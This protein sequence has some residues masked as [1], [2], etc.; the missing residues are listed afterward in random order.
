M[1]LATE[2]ERLQYIST[3]QKAHDSLMQA[4]KS[5]TSVGKGAQATEK[6]AW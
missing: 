3:M 2:S 5:L 4:A 1:E 6:E